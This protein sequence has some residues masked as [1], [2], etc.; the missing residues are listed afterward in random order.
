MRIR[1]EEKSTSNSAKRASSDSDSG[2]ASSFQT[3]RDKDAASV[4]TTMSSLLNDVPEEEEEDPSSAA[5][6]SEDAE[7]VSQ[8]H[9]QTDAGPAIQKFLDSIATP[10]DVAPPWQENQ[11]VYSET[12][13]DRFHDWRS[14]V[15]ESDQVRRTQVW[16]SI[17]RPKQFKLPFLLSPE[18]PPTFG[19]IH[20]DGDWK[21][22]GVRTG[23][24]W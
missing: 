17:D 2:Y 22:G 7:E 6:S 16:R 12:R 4:R 15:S 13:W 20:E 8:P 3:C 1:D 23:W 10:T 18:H 19:W 21:M 24:Q 9:Q 14:K 5:E 11:K